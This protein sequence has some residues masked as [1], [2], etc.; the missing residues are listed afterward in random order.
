MNEKFNQQ[1]LKNNATKLNLTAVLQQILLD[2]NLAFLRLWY[3]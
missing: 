2:S 1:N 3:Y